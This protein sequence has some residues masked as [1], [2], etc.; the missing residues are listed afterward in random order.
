MN[1]DVLACIFPFCDRKTKLRLIRAYRKELWISSA[2]FVNIEEELDIEIP[3]NV[4]CANLYFYYKKPSKLALKRLFKHSNSKSCIVGLVRLMCIK[5]REK[6]LTVL[7]E[8]LCRD[9]KVKELKLF[10]HYC[11]KL[12]IKK[13]LWL[14]FDLLSSMNDFASSGRNMLGYEYIV[15]YL[16]RVYSK[17]KFGI[18][19]ETMSKLHKTLSSPLTNPAYL[20]ALCSKLIFADGLY[21]Q[22]SISSGNCKAL[23]LII[24]EWKRLDKDEAI[25]TQIIKQ[26]IFDCDINRQVLDV[27][28]QAI[29]SE[30]IQ[31][32]ASDAFYTDNFQ[33]LTNIF[34][35]ESWS[36]VGIS[37]GNFLIDI[38][39]DDVTECDMKDFI[40][41]LPFLSL[42]DFDLDKLSRDSRKVIKHYFGK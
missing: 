39:D 28:L 6:F 3:K 26:S 19:F 8:Y 2:L 34:Q 24:E 40:T 5:Y 21:V 17:K 27:A 10:L 32:L 41:S 18:R 33:L 16:F 31:D 4:N 15:N 42:K 11:R 1:P 30:T 23:E 14:E 37:F 9:K 25:Y 38:L 29:N 13:E 36:K 35:S 20:I 7:L 22:A 12:R